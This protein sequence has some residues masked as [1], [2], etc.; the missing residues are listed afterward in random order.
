MQHNRV[1]F[2]LFLS[3]SHRFFSSILSLTLFMDSLS[4]FFTTLDGAQLL[5]NYSWGWF[6][7]TRS[8]HG[9]GGNPKW[10]FRRYPGIPR[11]WTPGNSV[12]PITVTPYILHVG[13]CY[14]V[15]PIHQKDLFTP[16]DKRYSRPYFV[17]YCS[18]SAKQLKKKKKSF[19][20]WYGKSDAWLKMPPPPL[21]NTI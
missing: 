20:K 1:P 4:L 9:P 16:Y 18:L 17:D 13:C 19:H 10:Q 7:L 8:V 5:E 12:P 14:N 2:F 21:P 11:R 15:G 6:S 3:I